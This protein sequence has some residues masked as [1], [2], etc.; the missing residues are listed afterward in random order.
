M[1]QLH[2]CN[3]TMLLTDSSTQL[4]KLLWVEQ[5]RYYHKLFQ[6]SHN[7]WGDS[8]EFQRPPEEKLF[9]TRSALSAAEP[10]SNKDT[11]VIEPSRAELSC[12]DLACCSLPPTRRV[13]LL[14]LKPLLLDLKRIRRWNQTERVKWRQNRGQSQNRDEENGRTIQRHW[15]KKSKERRWKK[16]APGWTRWSE[17]LMFATDVLKLSLKAK[18]IR[19][20]RNAWNISS[21]REKGFVLM[22]STHTL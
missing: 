8:V 4:I 7:W 13:T 22:H 16:R 18:R 1:S 5:P 12:E 11:A 17:V 10:S 9:I 19:R 14:K 2:F 6:P 21:I 15:N 20:E 3:V